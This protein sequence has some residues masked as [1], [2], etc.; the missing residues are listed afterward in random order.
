MA[1]NEHR[2]LEDSTVQRLPTLWRREP[3]T[4]GGEESWDD[5]GVWTKGVSRTVLDYEGVSTVEEYIDRLE[6]LT[7][8]PSAPLV[9]ATPSPLNLV[10]ALDYL[11]MAWRVAQGGPLF[12]YPSA[13]RAAKLAYTAATSEELDSRLTALGEILRTANATVRGMGGELAKTTYDEPLAPLRDFLGQQTGL[14][15]ARV[16]DALTRLEAAL[17]V[18]DAAQHTEAGGRAVIALAQ[19][20]GLS[21]PILDPA[22]AWVIISARVVSALTAIR[23]EVIANTESHD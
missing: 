12:S 23:E 10:S 4:W 9:E 7:A 1:H 14:D 13:E 15:A 21:H 5:E 3:A 19:Q 18:R 8:V 2:F 16:G 22:S 17:T 20:F 11:D 6:A